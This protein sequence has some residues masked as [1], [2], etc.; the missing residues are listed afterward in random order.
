[1]AQLLVEREVIFAD[2]VEQIF[3][4]RPWTSRA[5][6]LMEAQMR[7]DAERMAQEREQKLAKQAAESTDSEGLEDPV[8]SEAPEGSE[9]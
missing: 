6:E 9:K 8:G 5:E 7:A 4:K 2:D 1:L 3:G